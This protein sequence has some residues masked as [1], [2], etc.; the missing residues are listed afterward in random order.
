[1]QYS[2][3]PYLLYYNKYLVTNQFNSD[4]FEGVQ[5]LQYRTVNV[6]SSEVLLMYKWMSL[7]AAF[8]M[9]IPSMHKNMLNYALYFIRNKLPLTSSPSFFFSLPIPFYLP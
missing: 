7:R 5:Y 2:A 8:L 6:L 3:Y 1:M 4:E 9:L